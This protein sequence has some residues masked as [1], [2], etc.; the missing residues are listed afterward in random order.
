MTRT[1]NQS[2]GKR[3]Q[4][5]LQQPHSGYHHCR[6]ICR[7][8][9]GDAQFKYI[10]LMRLRSNR[11]ITH[12]FTAETLHKVKACVMFQYFYIYR[13]YNITH[14]HGFFDRRSDDRS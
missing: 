14:R 8:F 12:R 7:S 10:Y 11:S 4:K 1:K 13:V 2:Y 6:R 3:N 9:N 5:V